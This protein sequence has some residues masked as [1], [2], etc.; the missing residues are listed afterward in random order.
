MEL[1]TGF[2][3]NKVLLYILGGGGVS[4]L[5]WIFKKIPNEKIKEKFGKF[6]YGLGVACTLGLAKWKI[7]KNFWNAV[8]EPWVIDLIE[9]IIVHGITEFIRGMRSDNQ[10]E[11]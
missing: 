9:N 2:S 8:I 4:I 5:T 1:L 6:M 7:T 3:A 10:E 11:K